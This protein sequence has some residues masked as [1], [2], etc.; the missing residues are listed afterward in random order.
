MPTL[1][2]AS[3]EPRKIA[4]LLD[5]PQ[6]EADADAERD[7]NHDADARDRERRRPDRTQVGDAQ[8]EADF[9]QQQDHA[10]LAEDLDAPRFDSISPRTAGSDDD[11]GDDL[12]DDR[13]DADP[14]RDLRRDLRGEQHDDD[15]DAGCR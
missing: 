14:F 1:V 15:V 2:A 5:S 12:A 13:G 6:R 9:E 7:G 3:A 4:V 11:A 8:L 10:E